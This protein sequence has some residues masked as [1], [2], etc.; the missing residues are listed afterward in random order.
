MF[1]H[2]LQFLP[3]PSLLSLSP[4]SR[5][6]HV[7]LTHP[8]TWRLPSLSLSLHH[9]QH[10]FLSSLLTST[11]PHTLFHRLQHADLS[12]SL[13][14]HSSLLFIAH[15]R[16]LRSLRMHRSQFDA[17][18]I[19][20]L[21]SVLPCTLVALQLSSLTLSGRVMREVGRL[22]GLL[23]LDLHGSSG[24]GQDWTWLRAMRTLTELNLD[25]CE[26]VDDDA[27]RRILTAEEDQEGEV[28]EAALPALRS[29]RLSSPVITDESLRLIA[30]RCPRLRSLS[31]TG[32]RLITVDG[33]C[34]LASMPSL[35]ELSVTRCPLVYPNDST[36]SSHPFTSPPSFAL[37]PLLTVVA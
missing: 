24:L 11:L 26:G 6:H 4:L 35:D 37:L 19:A 14:S 31:L 7:A 33:L 2:L 17:P 25:G 23:R 12:F 1:L 5:Y 16:A 29:L 34:A 3:L 21:L 36:F 13:F 8:L 22:K 9:P 32:C 27:V 10:P 20:R 15:C 28:S 30:R 18:A